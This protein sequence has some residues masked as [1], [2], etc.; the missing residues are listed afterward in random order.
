MVVT[1]LMKRKVP[2]T[3]MCPNNV[4]VKLEGLAWKGKVDFKI[5][6]AVGYVASIDRLNT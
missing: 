2:V 6:T 5:T 4:T 1:E 3:A